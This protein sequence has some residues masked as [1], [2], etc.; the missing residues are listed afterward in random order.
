MQTFVHG[1]LF[2][3]CL[4]TLPNNTYL[5]TSKLTLYTYKLPLSPEAR[6]PS[7]NLAI[8]VAHQQAAL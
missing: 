8:Y 7:S 4:H 6:A 2:L 1:H 5:Y 3:L